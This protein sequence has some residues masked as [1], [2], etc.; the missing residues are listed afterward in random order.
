MY[1]LYKEIHSVSHW[2]LTY[3]HDHIAGF[4]IKSSIPVV[5]AVGRRHKPLK[6]EMYHEIILRNPL[7]LFSIFA[8]Q[9]FDIFKIIIFQQKFGK[10][11]S[12]NSK[13]RRCRFFEINRNKIICLFTRKWGFYN[14]YTKWTFDRSDFWTRVSK[15]TYKVHKTIFEL[16]KMF[17]PPPSQPK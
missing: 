1:N 16:A 17:A 9:N 8:K 13:R 6:H 15:S 2:N 12:E 10:I 14:F 5:K 3:N 11:W 7:Y 4:C